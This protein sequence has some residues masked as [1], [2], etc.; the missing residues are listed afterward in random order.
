M[1][2]AEDFKEW[3]NVAVSMPF[4][5]MVKPKQNVDVQFFIC[6]QYAGTV[7]SP[8][9]YIDI[10]GRYIEIDDAIRPSSYWLRRIAVAID[11]TNL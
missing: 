7:N 1:I 2:T 8:T 9:T 4:V 3:P 5:E 11:V 10:A 6:T